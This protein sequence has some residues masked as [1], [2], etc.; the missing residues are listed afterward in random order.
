MPDRERPDR[1]RP[2]TASACWSCPSVSTQAKRVVPGSAEREA[3]VVEDRPPILLGADDGLDVDQVGD[4]R[5]R[6]FELARE[7]PDRSVTDG[8]RR[9]PAL[10]GDADPF[11]VELRP[12]GLKRPLGRG[13]EEDVEDAHPGRPAGGGFAGPTSRNVTGSAFSTIGTNCF[14]PSTTDVMAIVRMSGWPA[15]RSSTS[16]P[17]SPPSIARH[18]VQDNRSS[19]PSR[20]TR[21][22]T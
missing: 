17:C 10:A 1:F 11:Q 19:S 14:C 16:V 9:P 22:P 2:S 20:S 13:V 21:D 8:D 15:R 18:E 3:G 5:R 4:P 6:Q 12:E 7:R